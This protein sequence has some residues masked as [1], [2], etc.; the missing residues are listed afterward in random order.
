MVGKIK[1][2]VGDE[3]ANVDPFACSL[4][5]EDICIFHDAI[6]TSCAKDSSLSCELR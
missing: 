4:G 6:E 5:G 3:M 1:V 2:V